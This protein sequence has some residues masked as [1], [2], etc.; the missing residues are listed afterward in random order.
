MPEVFSGCLGSLRLQEFNS[1]P[2]PQIETFRVF[3]TNKQETSVD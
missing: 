3:Y 1:P 2:K